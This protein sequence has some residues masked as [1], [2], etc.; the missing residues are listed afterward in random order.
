MRYYIFAKNA[1][2]AAYCAKQYGLNFN[3][4]NVH[5]VHDA[6][7]LYGLVKTD[8]VE[9]IKYET[10]MEHP[11]W[12]EIQ[13]EIWIV[14]S[15]PKPIER[16]IMS[17]NTEPNNSLWWKLVHLEPTLLRGVLTGLIGLAGALGILITP[18]L[19]DTILG[20]W[21]PLMAVLQIILTRSGVTANARVAVLVPDPVNA[22]QKV[23]PGEAVTTATD[24]NILKAARESGEEDKTDGS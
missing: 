2:H 1:Q 19:S 17:N 23:E 10:F 7:Q 11:K 16:V 20:F 9:F 22:P 4:P 13:Q 24:R 15:K 14:E 21:V 12:A 6:W 8:D 3:S 5:Y 18:G